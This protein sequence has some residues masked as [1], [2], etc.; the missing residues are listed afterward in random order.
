MTSPECSKVATAQDLYVIIVNVNVCAELYLHEVKVTLI[1]PV[2]WV[3]RGLGMDVN[4]VMLR[5][6]G[7]Y[8]GML[9]WLLGIRW[10]VE[11]ARKVR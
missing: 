4:R 5:V 9:I 3:F 10:F 8:Y 6:F 7:G 11:L 1:F 2:R